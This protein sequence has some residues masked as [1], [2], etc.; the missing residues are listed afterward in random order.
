MGNPT[1]E[2]LLKVV[3]PI[4]EVF[5]V[6]HNLTVIGD[7]HLEDGTR[8]HLVKDRLHSPIFLSGAW[9]VSRTTGAGVVDVGV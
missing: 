1:K 8:V 5:W 6:K 9:V 4:D 2:E 7:G 3:K